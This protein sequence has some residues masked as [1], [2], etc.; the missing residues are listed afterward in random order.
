[1]KQIELRDFSLLERQ[2][3]I[4]NFIIASPEISD[5]T[6]SSLFM[7]AQHYS[8]KLT[9]FNDVACIICTGGEFTP[10]LLMPVGYIEDKIKDIIDFFYN[11]FHERGLELYISHV[12]ERFLPLI[13]S[14]P[15]YSYRVNYNRDYSDYIYDKNNFVSMRGSSYKHFRKKI[16]SFQRHFPDHSYAPLSE[17]D[18]PECLELLELWR[19][20]K[21]YDADANETAYLLKNYRDLELKGGI[22]KIGGKIKAFILGELC[23]K[24]GFVISGKGDMNIHGLYICALREFVKNEFA[25]ATYINRCE[26]LGIKTLRE[27]KMSWMPSKILHKYNVLCLRL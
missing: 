24:M 3:Y 27:A 14:V 7:W 10:S 15:G 16:H 21:G 23:G 13:E 18:I 17:I 8:L 1:M 26:D 2:R 9:Y 11:W 19:I 4:K 22:I 5:F 12:D 6:F 20:Q 25:Q